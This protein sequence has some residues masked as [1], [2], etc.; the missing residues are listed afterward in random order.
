[1]HRE[2]SV[3]HKMLAGS[4]WVGLAVETGVIATLGAMLVG[5]GIVSVPLLPFSVLMV[6]P[7]FLWQ[8]LWIGFLLAS[9]TTLV[10]LPISALCSDGVR[11]RP[12][13]CCR[14]RD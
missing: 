2:S 7:P 1:M 8:V 6:L 3:V 5:I 13:T 14:S 9:P 10:I 12:C 4:G 11:W